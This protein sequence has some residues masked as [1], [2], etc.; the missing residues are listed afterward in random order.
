MSVKGSPK[1]EIPVMAILP[2]VVTTADKRVPFLSPFPLLKT[3]TL[4]L[5]QTKQSTLKIRLTEI[6][7]EKG[8]LNC[9]NHREDMSL[10]QLNSNT[11]LTEI[12]AEKGTL[13]YLKGF[14]ENKE[15][16]QGRCI[17]QRLRRKGR[18]IPHRPCA[19]RPDVLAVI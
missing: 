12:F 19:S 7:V 9:C 4:Y 13:N 1:L 15:V 17:P 18:T 16:D 8:S 6:L 5:F 11:L 10:F 2:F 14:C 3:R